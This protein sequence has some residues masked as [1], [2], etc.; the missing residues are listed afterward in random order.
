LYI[1]LPS[2]AAAESAGEALSC[3]FALVSNN[4][5][6][7]REGSAPLQE[8]ADI[9]AR[10]Q[11][12]VMLLAASD[13]SLLRV[14]V[15]PMS[16]A[17]LRAALPNLVEDQLITDPAECVVVAG[18][19]A[20][21]LRTVAVVEKAWLETLVATMISLGARQVGAL[22]AQLC[23]PWQPGAVSAAVT[24]QVAAID[25]AL[26]LSEQDG[27]GLPIMPTGPET[28]AQEVLEAVVALAPQGP[29]TVYVPLAALN[30]FQGAASRD[31]TLHA[32]ITFEADSWRRWIAGTAG[33]TLD[34]TAGLHRAG[35]PAV[36]WR[37][38][39]WPAILAGL[40]LLVNVAALNY[41]WWRFRNE[42]NAQ[43]A[44][45]T[46]IYR[47]AFPKETVV[48]DP[49]AQMQQKIA[50]AK[51]GSGQLAPDDFT[52]LT[53][54]FGEAWGAVGQNQPARNAIAAVDYRERSLFVRFKPG[55]TA[56]AEQMK[57]A[58]ASRGLALA[59]A[60]SQ[61]GAVVWQISTTR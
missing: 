26:R 25:L 50:V 10:S 12:V 31:D 16:S 48:I 5:A 20:D 33:A 38:W 27:I 45:M 47:S 55:A 23:L 24:A 41:D 2:K 1:R 13:V 54:K 14:K 58:L 37:P 9:V 39:R 40:L 3:L 11:R 21:G 18:G 44:A 30:D 59:E 34:L 8:L 36:N 53:A 56:P 19:Q 52:A 46:Q 60:P 61:G 49:L 17:R 4:G 22:P 7:E 29:V 57:G 35:S 43:R 32:R 51:R 15:P 28:T 42:A 6:I